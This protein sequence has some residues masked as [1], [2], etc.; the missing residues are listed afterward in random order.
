MKQKMY[1]SIRYEKNLNSSKDEEN[2][3]RSKNR[4][5]LTNLQGYLKI[6]L[7]KPFK[8]MGYDEVISLMNNKKNADL[9][10]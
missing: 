10:N 3:F 6:Y 8:V 9:Q 4:D 2:R 7:A 1:G 5:S